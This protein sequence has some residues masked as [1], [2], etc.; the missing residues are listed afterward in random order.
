MLATIVLQPPPIGDSR[1]ILYPVMVEPP[2]DGAVQ[3]RLICEEDIVVATSPIG[4]EGTVSAGEEDA[5][6]AYPLRTV[7]PWPERMSIDTLQVSWSVG[8]LNTILLN[9]PLD[10][11]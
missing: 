2:S 4:A 1:S 5:H 11:L 10:T 8:L 7:G 6:I 3:D 9:S